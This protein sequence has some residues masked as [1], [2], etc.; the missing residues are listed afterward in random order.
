MCLAMQTRLLLPTITTFLC[1]HILNVK[2]DSYLHVYELQSHISIR[3]C[4]CV[5]VAILS[6]VSEAIR[7]LLRHI[8]IE[9]CRLVPS[10]DMK[11]VIPHNLSVVFLEQ[12]CDLL[13]SAMADH[14]WE[15]CQALI[16]TLL[17]RRGGSEGGRVMV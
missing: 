16:V 11:T 6:S 14:D 4:V 13:S 15:N 10:C 8:G 3:V 5:C 12:C 17:V 1:Y 2:I 7:L 9:S